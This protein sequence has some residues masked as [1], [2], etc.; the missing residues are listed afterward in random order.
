MA[1]G[2]AGARWPASAGWCWFLR[3]GAP[4]GERIYECDE[5]NVD[6]FTVNVTFPE[7]EPG[8]YTMEAFAFWPT[9]GAQYPLTIYTGAIEVLANGSAPV[10]QTAP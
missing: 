1:A 3:D 4:D 6:R 9:A 2:R 10:A 8:G 5:F 7:D